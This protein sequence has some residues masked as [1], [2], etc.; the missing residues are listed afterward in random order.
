MSTT[1]DIE[2]GG[3][4]DAQA[5]RAFGEH[6]TAIRVEVCRGAD[7]AG[8]QMW[9]TAGAIILDTRVGA[10]AG[11]HGAFLYRD[12]YDGPALSP[13]LDPR[14]GS[15][16][17]LQHGVDQD[18]RSKADMHPVFLQSLPDEWGTKVLSAHLPAY[19][20]ADASERL[21]ILASQ[22]DC[23]VGA[24]RF[25]YQAGSL[26]QYVTGLEA[27]ERMQ[28]AVNQFLTGSVRRFL[29]RTELWSVYS[30]G[31][32]QPKV[33]FKLNA[34]DPDS[35]VA[36]FGTQVLGGY[37]Q[38]KVEA[39]CMAIARDAGVTVPVGKLMVLDDT[40]R[41]IYL[42]KRFDEHN[43]VP[44][45]RINAAVALGRPGKYDY[46]TY[47]ELASAVR[48][49]SARP[50]LDGQ[51]LFGRMLVNAYL[52]NTDDHLGQFEFVAQPNGEYRLAPAFDIQIDDAADRPHLCRF[53]GG[54][55]R[56]EYSVAWIY[57][58]ADSMGVDRSYALQSAAKVLEQVERAPQVLEKARVS[59]GDMA[60]VVPQLQLERVAQLR[61]NVS[62]ELE[63][64]QHAE[65]RTDPQPA[66]PGL[67]LRR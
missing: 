38:P 46:A 57:A 15:Y 65:V 47:A 31:G 62:A 10:K 5:R 32:A 49:I 56:P 28:A 12:G 4:L 36:K 34:G 51:E 52:N 7:A 43:G 60:R 67:R 50:D 37:D 54:Q 9:Q 27:A 66:Q 21:A 2:L 55:D 24:L 3:D 20:S 44:L 61:R 11:Y 23:R 16:F 13:Q 35:W 39:A 58:Q 59:I 33:A 42:S 8:R 64:S 30:S 1:H 14:N 26:N 17:P 53:A 18:V 19:A 22:G 25:D 6:A 45:H 41:S 29:N 48:S 40:G 63:R